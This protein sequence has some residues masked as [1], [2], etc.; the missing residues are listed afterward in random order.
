MADGLVRPPDLTVESMSAAETVGGFRRSHGPMTARC[1]N[2]DEPMKEPGRDFQCEPCRRIIIFFD[3]SDTSPY[4][5][6]GT[7]ARPGVASMAT[8]G[9]KGRRRDRTFYPGLATAL[10]P[11]ATLCFVLG[12]T[13]FAAG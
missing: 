7:G 9:R 4:L 11:R 12:G 10:K 8:P 5:A 13:A 6:A 3:V 1:P 2:C